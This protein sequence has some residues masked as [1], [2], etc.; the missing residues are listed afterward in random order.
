MISLTIRHC[1][2]MEQTKELLTIMPRQIAAICI[3]TH[4]GKLD[5]PFCMTQRALLYLAFR[6][7]FGVLTKSRCNAI[8][9]SS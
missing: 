9:L 3:R 6:E 2:I 1:E 5:C 8:I 7:C 4:T